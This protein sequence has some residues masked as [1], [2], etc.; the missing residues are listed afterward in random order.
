MTQQASVRPGPVTAAQ[1]II[2]V[3]AGLSAIGAAA[4]IVLG[5]VGLISGATVA[6]RASSEGASGL[7]GA[8]GGAIGLFAGGLIVIGVIWAAFIVLWFWLASALGKASRAAQ[9]ITTVLCGLDVLWGL[10][11]LVSVAGAR[12]AAAGLLPAIVTLA[13]PATI[14]LLLWAPESSRRYFDGVPAMV[15]GAWH[16]STPMGQPYAAQQYPMSPPVG[17][18]NPRVAGPHVDDATTGPISLPA[19][20][21]GTCQAEVKA[22]SGSCSSCGSSVQQRQRPVGA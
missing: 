6:S 17:F 4:M 11:M 14:I 21:C 19:P 2:W 1:V 20:R 5:I 3:V 10:F 16:S 15:P 9:I 8:L 7:G 18:A 22:G 12:G 13:V